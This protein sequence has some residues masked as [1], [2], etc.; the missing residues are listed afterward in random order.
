MKRSITLIVG[1]LLT[2]CL[3]GSVWFMGTAQVVSTAKRG[4]QDNS[5]A[6]V[7]R[8]RAILRGVPGSGIAGVVTFTQRSEDS[9]EP[10]VDVVARVIGRLGDLRPGRHGMHIHEFARCEPPSFDSAG[11]HF[12]PGM[13]GNSTPVDL[14][15][16]FH[17]GDIPNLIV[18]R[19]RNFSVGKLKHQ[20]SR[21]T[22]SDGPL[23]VFD[24]DGSAVILHLNEDR[25]E[26][27]VTG[28]SGG[29]R[30]ACGVIERVTGEHS[31]DDMDDLSNIDDLS[32]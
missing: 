18:N 15:H 26:P 24:T 28:A 2:A 14:N 8:A 11:G 29:A 21:I 1:C 5:R 27:G 32:N 22:L 12:D 4:A 13:F 10:G 31:S 30:I 7:L 3:I 6:P 19:V 16:P 25:G 9:P 23:S 17:M 20:T